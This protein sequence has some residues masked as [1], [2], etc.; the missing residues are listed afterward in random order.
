MSTDR[1]DLPTFNGRDVRE[2]AT[3]AAEAIRAINHITGWPAGLTYPQDAYTVLNRMARAVAMLPQALH[4]LDGWISQWQA[5]GHIGIDRGT[6]YAGNS[7]AAVL[8]ALSALDEAAPLAAHLY[9]ALDNAVQPM[10][11][12]HWTGPD[13]YIEIVDDRDPGHP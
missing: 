7:Q 11:A 8:A 3:D 4:Q 12:A 9:A 13:P 5:A 1:P 10:A 6:P 2:H